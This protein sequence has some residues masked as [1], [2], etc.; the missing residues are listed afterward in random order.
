MS[1]P[2]ELVCAGKYKAHDYVKGKK[3]WVCIGCDKQ[4]SARRKPTEKESA[5]YKRYM[6]LRTLNAAQEIADNLEGGPLNCLGN[7]GQQ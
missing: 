3:W 5:D 7:V 1:R 2:K 6:E 4:R